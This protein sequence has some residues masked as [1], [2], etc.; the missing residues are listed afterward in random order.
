MAFE[1]F[2]IERDEA[3]PAD[4]ALADIA[5]LLGGGCACAF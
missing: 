1:H 5:A 4:L 2:L 3:H